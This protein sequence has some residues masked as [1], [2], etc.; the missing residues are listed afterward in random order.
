MQLMTGFRDS[1]WCGS[2]ENYSAKDKI[3]QILLSWFQTNQ[4]SHI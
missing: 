2:N 4:N 3:K 1:G